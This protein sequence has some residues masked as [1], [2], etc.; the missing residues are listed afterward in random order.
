MERVK[1]TYN[2][3][4]A[5]LIDSA[6]LCELGPGTP[7]RAARANLDV[8]TADDITSPHKLADRSMA[9]ACLSGLWLLH[10]YLNESHEISQKLNGATGAYWHGIMHRRELDYSNAKYWFCRVSVH[11]IYE[12]LGLSARS[13]A[14]DFEVGASENR[15]AFLRNQRLWDPNRFIGL[16]QSI[17]DEDSELNLLCRHVQQLEWQML[18]DYCYQA[19]V[20]QPLVTKR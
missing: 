17:T 1:Q 3:E 5:F 13:A 4:V 9:Q 7:N 12:A 11:P 16:C 6:G 8:L 15:A 19:A 14:E 18:F 10:N 2:S 20:Y